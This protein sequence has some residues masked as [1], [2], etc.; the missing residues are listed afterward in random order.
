MQLEELEALVECLGLF[1]GDCT[2]ITINLLSVVNHLPHDD[3]NCV[4]FSDGEVEER[5][6]I[7]PELVKTWSL[8]MRQRPL[9]LLTRNP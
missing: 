9:L 1:S 3:Y 8:S 5:T 6:S 4:L 2:L 7:L